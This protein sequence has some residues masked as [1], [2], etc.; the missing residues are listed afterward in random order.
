MSALNIEIWDLFDDLDRRRRSERRRHEEAFRRL[1]LSASARDSL[2]IHA[3]A[4]YCDASRSFDA[5]VAEIEGIV[6]K[7][8]R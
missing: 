3:W 4:S 7:L 2:A 5:C 8:N 6:W 1:D